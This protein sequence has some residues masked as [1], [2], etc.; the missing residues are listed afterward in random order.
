MIAIGSDHRGFKL[1]EEIKVFLDNNKLIYNEETKEW[2]TN[3]DLEY[4]DFGT[5]S[6]DRVDTLPIADAVCKAIQSGECDRG[7]LICG[8]G[9]AMNIIANKHKGIMATPIY[10]ELL[11]M[12]SKEHNESNV[13]ILGAE[14]NSTIDNCRN[15]AI[16]L[17]S[18][19]LG[20]KYHERVEGI[21]NWESNNG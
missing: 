10:N 8:T 20:E 9:L 14:I 1:K 5:F 17:H 7:I 19:P 15:L 13:A 11:A 6:E 2:E 12:R 16:W 18:K 21:L 3:K 4:K